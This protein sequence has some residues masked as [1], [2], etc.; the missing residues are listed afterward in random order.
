MPQTAAD[1]WTGW[2]YALSG[3]LAHLTPEALRLNTAVTVAIVAGSAATVWLLG[4]L[5]RWVLRLTPG[6][7]K[8]ERKVHALQALQLTTLILRGV[9]VIYALILVA[10]TWGVDLTAWATTPWGSRFAT[11]GSRVVII[12]VISA[13]FLEVA[14]LGLGY[15][16]GRLKSRAGG[17]PRRASQIDTLSPIVRSAVQI[18]IFI[19][20]AMTLLSQVG[21]EVAP[22]LASAGVVGIAIGFGAQTLVRDFFTGFFLIIEDI[23]AIGDVVQIQ[24]FSGTVEQMTLR[25][26]RLR[27]FDGTLHIFPYGEAQIIHNLTKTYS[28]AA[29]DLP[30]RYDSDIDKAVEVMRTTAEDLRGDAEFGPMILDDIEIPGT[31]LLSDI[32]IIIKARIRTQPRERW[33]VFRE[34]N[35]RLKPAFDAAGIVM[36]HK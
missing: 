9:A 15:A 23:V 4:W 25:T 33:L 16:M 10:R 29:F 13:I 24:S 2:W 21:V 35:R 5:P 6:L 31:D 30:L 11:T 3:H 32:G 34:Y 28:Y 7:G 27:D 36:T 22:L 12:L 8:A 17:D 19:I 1:Q 26:I 14:G 20:A 18:T